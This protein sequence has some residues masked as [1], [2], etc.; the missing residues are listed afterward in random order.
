MEVNM[1]QPEELLAGETEVFGG[2]LPQCLFC[3]PQIPRYLT[4][5]RTH[6]PMWTAAD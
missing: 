1:E 5:I 2:N 6:P 3:P 4:R